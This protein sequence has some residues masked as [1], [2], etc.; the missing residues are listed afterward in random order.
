M[1]TKHNKKRYQATPKPTH[2]I[3]ISGRVFLMYQD[4]EDMEKAARG[5]LRLHPSTK[6]LHDVYQG[7]YDTTGFDGYF[8]VD[9]CSGKDWLPVILQSLFPG[10]EH[11]FGKHECAID[12]YEMIKPQLEALRG[13]TLERTYREHYELADEVSDA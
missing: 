7:S 12:V 3:V 9:V 13:R 4:D 11:H 2:P 6:E 8:R 10:R 1:P 5:D